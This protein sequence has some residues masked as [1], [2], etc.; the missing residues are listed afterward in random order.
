MLVCI[1]ACMY[2]FVYVY[3]ERNRD[4]VLHQYIDSRNNLIFPGW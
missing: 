2:I 4:K 1:Y 3:I